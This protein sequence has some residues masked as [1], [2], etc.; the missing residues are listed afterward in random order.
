MAKIAIPIVNGQLNCHFGQTLQFHIFK[1]ENNSIIGKEVVTPPSHEPGVFPEW[2][3]EMGVTDVIAHS[4]G[5]KAIALLNK[6]KIHV[7]VGVVKKPPK[8]LVLEL[9]KGTLETNDNTC[10]Q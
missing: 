9:L 8:E 10:L 6:N 1:I 4:I 5:Q 2:L 7:F 3:T